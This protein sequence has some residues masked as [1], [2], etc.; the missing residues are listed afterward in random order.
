MIESKKKKKKKQ[1]TTIGDFRFGVFIFIFAFF[2][3]LLY[4]LQVKDNILI[5]SPASDSGYY[6]QRATEILNGNF[7]GAELSFHSA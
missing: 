2:L 7:I 6:F 1:K 4:L 5:Q 3:R